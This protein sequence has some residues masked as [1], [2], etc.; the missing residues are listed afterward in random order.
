MNEAP[1]GCQ[2]RLWYQKRGVEPDRPDTKTKAIFERGHR[3]EPLIIQEYVQKTSRRVHRGGKLILHPEYDYMALHLDGKI[4]RHIYGGTPGVLE[5][6]TMG[7]FP[8][9]QAKRYGL[10]TGYILQVQGA[11][12]VTGWAWGAF[13][14]LWPDG[15][16][17]ETWD[18]IRDEELIGLL[19]DAGET[20]WTKV[21]NGPAPDRLGH[22]DPRCKRCLWRAGCWEISL[23]EVEKDKPPA[24]KDEDIPVDDSFSPMLC[25]LRDAEAMADDAT[26]TVDAIKNQL[27]AKM[28]ERD[29][30][31]CPGFRVYYRKTKAS[32]K[33]DR[34][35][36]RRE[37]PKIDEL[38][39]IVGKSSRPLKVF[40]QPT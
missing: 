15:W 33:L 19:K 25:D 37:Y 24:E 14:V 40:D 36:L 31:R 39:T 9:R 38:C 5:C 12:L 3:L 4:A 8:F 16:E 30:I 2:R 18:F 7:E 34:D 21:L 35:K 11:L 22:E 32:E 13:A 23:E 6:K 27:R 28:G 1:Y 29:V 17:L 26:E 20:F 10:P